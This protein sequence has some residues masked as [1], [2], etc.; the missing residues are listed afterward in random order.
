MQAQQASTKPR[1]KP[2]PLLTQ[3]MW[4]YFPGEKF[5]TIFGGQ[6]GADT[7]GRMKSP[8]FLQTKTFVAS[9][10]VHPKPEVHS[11]CHR[12]AAALADASSTRGS[13][14]QPLPLESSVSSSRDLSWIQE[15]WRAGRSHSFH[16]SHLTK[17]KGF[18]CMIQHC[19]AGSQKGRRHW[20]R[21]LC[22][23]WSS[24]LYG[25]CSSAP[26]NPL[27]PSLRLRQSCHLTWC[28]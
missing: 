17:W 26:L 20:R 6:D 11:Q 8:R 10:M 15:L 18:A 19:R 25:K 2:Q 24:V 27:T 5:H 22:T 23:A 4:W 12:A 9:L 13:L 16:L 21:E 1:Q 28:C 3:G 7:Q 14:M